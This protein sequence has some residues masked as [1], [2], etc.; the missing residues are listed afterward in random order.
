MVN[1]F[2][3]E[4][5][6]PQSECFPNSVIVENFLSSL[7]LF[8]SLVSTLPTLTSASAHCFTLGTWSW[9]MANLIMNPSSA[10]R[11]PPSSHTGA[12]IGAMS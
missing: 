7:S 3:S 12:V 11:W 1:P 6:Y 2:K 8:S 9:V 4:I 10:A 5:I